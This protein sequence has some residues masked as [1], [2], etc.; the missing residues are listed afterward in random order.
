MEK[1]YNL[2]RQRQL[3]QDNY[4]IFLNEEGNFGTALLI[5]ELIGLIL[6]HL[7]Q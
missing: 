6:A 3:E 2:E 7:L 5:I 4:T 1:K